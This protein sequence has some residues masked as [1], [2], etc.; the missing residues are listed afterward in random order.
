LLKALSLS[1]GK[2][3]RGRHFVP[4]WQSPSTSSGSSKAAGHEPLGPELVAEG[5]AKRVE[6]P[7]PFF[8]G[9]H[10]VRAASGSV[11]A[12]VSGAN[13][14]GLPIFGSKKEELGIRI[15]A[16]ARLGDPKANHNSYFLNPNCLRS[17]SSTYRAP[18]FERGGCRRNSCWEHQSY[19][20]GVAQRRGS[21]LRPRLVRVQVLPPGPLS[22]P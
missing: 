10:D 9:D 3:I 11:K 21:E 6:W 15:W 5:Q 8:D 22:L 2:S 12:V 4:A 17:C 14:T 18:R 16:E 13:P 19:F 7:D 1:K 20:P